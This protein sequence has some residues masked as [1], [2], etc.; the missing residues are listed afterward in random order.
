MS[1][2]G[3]AG[4]TEL[5]HLEGCPS[6]RNGGGDGGAGGDGDLNSEQLTRLPTPK[7]PL[8]PP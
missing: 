6:A 2:Q 4:L 8:D 1:G 5:P 3:L 7:K